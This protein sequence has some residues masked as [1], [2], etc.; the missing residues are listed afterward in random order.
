MK[1]KYYIF[2]S[3]Q[4]RVFGT[5]DPDVAHDFSTSFDYFVISPCDNEWIT[6]S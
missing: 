6:D 5:N 3:D 4:G 2:D 1:F